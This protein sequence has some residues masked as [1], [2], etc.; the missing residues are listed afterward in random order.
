M[1]GANASWMIEM[2]GWRA[3]AF[4]VRAICG[5]V[6]LAVSARWHWKAG[7]S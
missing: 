1:E 6:M 4:I 3:T 7:I 2:P 5:A